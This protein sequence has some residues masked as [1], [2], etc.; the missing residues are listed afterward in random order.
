MPVPNMMP[1]MHQQQYFNMQGPSPF[2]PPGF[3][4]PTPI[5]HLPE[6]RNIPVTNPFCSPGFSAGVA[7]FAPPLISPYQVNHCVP[8]NPWSW[9]LGHFSHPAWTSP[10]PCY[11]QA[12]AQQVRF[13][14]LFCGNNPYNPNLEI[15]SPRNSVQYPGM[16]GYEA[17]GGQHQP[18]KFREMTQES[19]TPYNSWE[20]AQMTAMYGCAPS[21]ASPAF[22]GRYPPVGQNAS[23]HSE[24]K[25]SFT[26]IHGR[27]VLNSQDHRGD[28][29]KSFIQE[30]GNT[31]FGVS[32][33]IRDNSPFINTSVQNNIFEK[34]PPVPFYRGP[35]A[36]QNKHYTDVESGFGNLG[37]SRQFADQGYVGNPTQPRE[38]GP[39]P[40]EHAGD[41]STTVLDENKFDGE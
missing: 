21:Y 22:C 11:Q 25:S 5:P 37:G 13:M 38:R 19:S 24:H 14:S 4:F 10:P 16:L 29:S 2:L 36:Q 30:E 23:N 32:N 6:S 12:L 39:G 18:A 15:S 17:R 27:G 8:Q 40:M 28:S 34:I 26:N 41:A 35:W 1:G 3:G 20:Q 33:G 31:A 7:N 9:Q